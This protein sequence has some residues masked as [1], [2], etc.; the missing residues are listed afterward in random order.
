MRGVRILFFDT[1]SP[2][3]KT[4]LNNLQASVGRLPSAVG[5]HLLCDLFFICAYLRHLRLIEARQPGSQ[6]AM[7]RIIELFSAF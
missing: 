5:R 2:L 6:A 3:A 1:A 4:R 7:Q